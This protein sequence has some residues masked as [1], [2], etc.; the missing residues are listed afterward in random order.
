MKTTA[1]ILIGVLL[2]PSIL[3]LIGHNDLVSVLAT[4]GVL[5]LLFEVGLA[6]DHEELRAV[7]RS[8]IVVAL[9]GVTVTF[10]GGA[11]VFVALGYHGQAAFFIGASITA[12]SVGVTAR[13]FR[14]LRVLDIVEARTVL[15]AAVIDDIVGLFVLAIALRLVSENVGVLESFLRLDVIAAFAIGLVVA[16]GRFGAK[17]SKAVKPIGRL[18]IPFFFVKVGLDLDVRRATAGFIGIAVCLLVI[19][20]LGKVLAA[21]GAANEHGDTL[22]IGLGLLPRGEVTLIFAGVGLH[23][24]VITQ[25]VYAA[26]VTVVLVTALATPVLLKWRL[27][28][29]IVVP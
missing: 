5:I 12:T 4:S 11:V 13:V 15:G 7:G 1:E 8:A 22:L 24:A 20:A 2:G 10:V 28:H 27:R 16:R 21:L 14:E 29:T 19:A 6:M 18:I 26:L 25:N 9:I 3:G 17:L 23:E